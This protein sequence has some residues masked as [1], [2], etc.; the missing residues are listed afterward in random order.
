MEFNNIPTHTIDGLLLSKWGRISIYAQDELT[1]INRKLVFA[2]IDKKELIKRLKIVISNIN[3]LQL[4][5]QNK[6]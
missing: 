3:K 5:K 6:L 1:D 2:T 4:T